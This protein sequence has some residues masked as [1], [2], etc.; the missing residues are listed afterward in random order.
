M[1]KKKRNTG[2]QIRD[3]ICE[4]NWSGVEA[5]N[6]KFRDET[7]Y[8]GCDDDKCKDTGEKDA[9]DVLKYAKWT[10]RFSFRCFVTDYAMQVPLNFI[11]SG[12]LLF[13]ESDKTMRRFGRTTPEVE[14]KVHVMVVAQESTSAGVQSGREWHFALKGKSSGSV[15]TISSEVITALLQSTQLD[16]RGTPLDFD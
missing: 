2:T 12:K 16:L 8:T 11:W 1:S 6:E 4:M 5:M 3:M 14:E 10:Y 9:S 7:T 13:K 15:R